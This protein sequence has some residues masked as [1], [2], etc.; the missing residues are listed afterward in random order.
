MMAVFI[1]TNPCLYFGH[2]PTRLLVPT[3]NNEYAVAKTGSQHHPVFCLCRANLA[4]D[5]ELYLKS[6]GRK[7]DEWQKKH[8]YIE[9]PFDDNSSAF[10]NINT[11]E[12]LKDL[13]SKI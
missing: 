4:Q 3:I 5:L 7:V 11:P 10:L 1:F 2:A 12:E 8:A 9:V 13:E 6:G